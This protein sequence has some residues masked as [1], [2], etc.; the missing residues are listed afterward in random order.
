MR[1]LLVL[2]CAW[3]PA[4]QSKKRRKRKQ[5][6]PE[7]VQIHQ[8][9]LCTGCL[10]F[11]EDYQKT[12]SAIY[13]RG[14]SDGRREED[15]ILPAEIRQDMAARETFYSREMKD[16]GRYLRINALHRIQTRFHIEVESQQQV[17]EKAL[18]LERKRSLCV[19]EL[20][21]CAPQ[22]VDRVRPAD[23]CGA[24]RALVPDLEFLA[25]R[26]G[27]H[28]PAGASFKAAWLREALA[29]AC[30]DVSFRHARPFNVE[31]FCVEL[32]DDHEDG[33][34]EAVQSF[35]AAVRAREIPAQDLERALCVGVAGACAAGAVKDARPGG[36]L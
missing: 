33:V 23:A 25:K 29:G 16:A 3:A 12:I 13:E 1:W 35:Y 17:D 4:A 34:V 28:T 18:V 21:A 14:N 32:F 2:C 19:D 15:H 24:C 7:R 27:L 8:A 20:E 11:V 6:A 31:A 36:E 10:A 5:P 30:E 26:A 22:V 9:D